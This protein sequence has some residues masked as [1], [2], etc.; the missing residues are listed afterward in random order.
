MASILRAV[1]S[2]SSAAIQPSSTTTI[3]SEESY[4]LHPSSYFVQLFKSH[5]GLSTLV[6]IVLSLLILEQAIYRSKK[7][8]LPGDRWTIPIIG[9]FADSVHPTLEGYQRQWD[10]GALSAISVFNM[11][12]S[13]HF[14]SLK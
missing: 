4:A 6:T 5:P 1:S 13:I 7:Q 11:Y 8:R 2:Y 14:R 12:V 3:P 9:K 10:L